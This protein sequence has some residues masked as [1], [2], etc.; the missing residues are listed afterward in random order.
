MAMYSDNVIERQR[1]IG[2]QLMLVNIIHVEND[3]E[4]RGFWGNRMTTDDLSMW[5][6]I[7]RDEIIDL[8]DATHCLYDN[9]LA[10]DFSYELLSSND[11]YS[12]DCLIYL[13]ETMLNHGNMV[14]KNY[15]KE[16]ISEY[17][18]K[19]AEKNYFNYKKK[20]PGVPVKK[21][22]ATPQRF[23]RILEYYVKSIIHTIEEVVS[24]GYDWAV[25][26][27]MLR[28][29]LTEEKYMK[30]AKMF[31]HTVDNMD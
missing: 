18:I 16:F 20:Y 12:S 24:E 26:K 6:L 8:I 11:D 14:L 1:K 31:G 27:E 29:D 17:S 7:E 25:I 13:E 3:K 30:L 4:I 21:E 5:S 19:E 28:C 22:Y 9:L 23:R 15:G 2:K 10:Q